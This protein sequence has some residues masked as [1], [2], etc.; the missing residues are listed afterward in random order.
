MER[1]GG[2]AVGFDTARHPQ[3]DR[4]PGQFEEGT[5]DDD[6][7]GFEVDVMTCERK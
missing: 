4:L 7:S 3:H 1:A 6:R 2:E 5:F